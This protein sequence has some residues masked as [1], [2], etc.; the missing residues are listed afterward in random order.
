M[1][2]PLTELLFDDVI[3]RMSQT[4]NMDEKE[5]IRQVILNSLLT[6]LVHLLPSISDLS[7]RCRYRLVLI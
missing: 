4:A 2:L 6:S 3:A 7:Q 1:A 5:S